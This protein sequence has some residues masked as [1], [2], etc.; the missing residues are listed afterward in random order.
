M[1]RRT[2]ALAIALLLAAIQVAAEPLDKA[3]TLQYR[4]AWN[5]FSAARA[6]IRVIP[7]RLGGFAS[8]TVETTAK[9]NRFV[10]LFYSF[11]GRA[12]VIFLARNQVPVQF[13]YD[14][15]IRGVRSR[16][17]VDFDLRQGRAK[18]RYVKG[19]VTKKQLDLPSS[20]LFDPISAIFHARR[21]P[22]HIGSHSGYDIFTGESRYRVEL[23]VV[24]RDTIEVPAGTFAALRITPSVMKVFDDRR[25]PDPRLRQATIWV[26][27]DPEHILLQ[28]RSEIFIGAI[29][30]DLV[31]HETAS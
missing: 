25:P 11:R 19:G 6:T 28:I 7:D 30:L 31:S 18:S 17:V 22:S 21:G 15:Q 4:L 9:T 8:Y 3:Q 20:N 5:G 10:D 16:T 24:G 26:S 29:T 12:R 13:Y 2:T 27:D 14:R 23:T 1:T